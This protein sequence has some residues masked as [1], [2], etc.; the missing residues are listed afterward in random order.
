[1]STDSITITQG[2]IQALEDDRFKWRTTKGI[3]SQVGISQE[4]VLSVLDNSADIVQSSVPSSD[5][6]PLFTTRNHF[7]AKCS[8]F[9]KI[10]GAFKGRIR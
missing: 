6:S 9:H 4:D 1:M 3:A 10:L 2:V 5:G 7:Q 8:L